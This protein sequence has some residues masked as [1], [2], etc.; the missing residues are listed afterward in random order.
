MSVASQI[1]PHLPYLRRYARALTGSQATGDAL[2]AT[3]LE[4]MI[5]SRRG[6]P[7]GVA[8]RLALYRIFQET[9][10]TPLRADPAP[11]D[12]PRLGAGAAET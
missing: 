8:P 5:A 6:L 7:A 3:T 1:A 2:V 12:R 10:A 4:T 11:A 9:C